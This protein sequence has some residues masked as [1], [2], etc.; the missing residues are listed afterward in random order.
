[1]AILVN[2]VPLCDLCI[3]VYLYKKIYNVC[4]MA[5]KFLR[6]IYIQAMRCIIRAIYMPYSHYDNGCTKLYV[7]NTF[8]ACMGDMHTL[9]SVC[10]V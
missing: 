6:R 2:T 10:S 8:N 4:R 7:G 3:I 1:M 9:Q 5:K